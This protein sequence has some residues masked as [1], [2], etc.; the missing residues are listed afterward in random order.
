VHTPPINS[1]LTE[2]HRIILGK[3]ITAEKLRTQ[4]KQDRNQK[5]WMKI[6]RIEARSFPKS[7]VTPVK[8]DRRDLSTLVEMTLYFVQDDM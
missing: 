1:E 8:K 3:A 5:T 2:T 7:D 4:R 6:Y